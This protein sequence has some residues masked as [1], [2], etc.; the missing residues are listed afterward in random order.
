[1][2]IFAYFSNLLGHRDRDCYQPEGRKHPLEQ[3]SS[4][5]DP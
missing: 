3:I 5:H 4:D 1:M 2:L